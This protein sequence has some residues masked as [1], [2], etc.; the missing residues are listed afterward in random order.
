M[1][2]LQG[3][4]KTSGK[5]VT[6]RLQTTSIDA[7]W[8]IVVQKWQRLYGRQLSDAEIDR[9]ERSDTVDFNHGRW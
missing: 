5:S 3:I 9:L 1:I 6:P 4:V 2:S 8:L 7:A